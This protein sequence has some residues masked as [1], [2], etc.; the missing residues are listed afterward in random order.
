MSEFSLNFV[1]I[2]YDTLIGKVSYFMQKGIIFYRERYD[3][4]SPSA[5]M[6][7]PAQPRTRMPL[8]WREDGVGAVPGAV[9]SLDNGCVTFL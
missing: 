4:L 5:R 7:K 2:R 1:G 8:K 3:T 6:G 9:G